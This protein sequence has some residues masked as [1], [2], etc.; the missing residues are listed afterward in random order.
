MA[1]KKTTT[2]FHQK[3]WSGSL[4]TGETDSWEGKESKHPLWC[5]IANWEK[6]REKAL[7]GPRTL[8]EGTHEDKGSSKKAFQR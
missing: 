8:E 7:T 2:R 5:D 3:I 4:L 1:T 6:G